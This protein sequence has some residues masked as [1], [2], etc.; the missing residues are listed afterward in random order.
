MFYSS[1]RVR[2]ELVIGIQKIM[3]RKKMGQVV[4]LGKKKLTGERKCN[5][6]NLC[7]SSVNIFLV[8]ILYIL[9][10]DLM[11]NCDIVIIIAEIY[12]ALTM[13]QALLKMLY[14]H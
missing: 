4:I 2:N 8:I 5:L 3:Q 13:L 9:D 12:M 6:T 1:V 7:S 14:M 10:F 11:K